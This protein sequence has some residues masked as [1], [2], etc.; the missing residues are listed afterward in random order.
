MNKFILSES[1]RSEILKKHSSYKRYLMENVTNYTLQ[2]LQTVL[3]SK[4]GLDLGKSGVDGKFG[5]MTKNAIIQAL[6]MVKNEFKP[7][8]TIKTSEEK[9]GEEIKTPEGKPESGTEV[10]D[11]NLANAET[12]V[13]TATLS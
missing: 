12:S 4:L 1:E 13:D 10:G 11:V 6:D 3:Q 7:I 5:K 2:D 9:P 8:E